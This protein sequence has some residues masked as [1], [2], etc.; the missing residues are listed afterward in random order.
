MENSSAA[1]Y[2][3]NFY[4]RFNAAYLRFSCVS[5]APSSF[6]FKNQRRR[7]RREEN[8][9][10]TGKISLGSRGKSRVLIFACDLSPQ[11]LRRKEGTPSSRKTKENGKIELLTFRFFFYYIFCVLIKFIVFF[12]FSF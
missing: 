3:W 2:W 5:M 7:K 9:E 4:G 6:L 12:F 11:V 8:K 10:E 1:N